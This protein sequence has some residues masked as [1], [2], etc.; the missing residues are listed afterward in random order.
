M[1]YQTLNLSGVQAAETSATAGRNCDSMVDKWVM[2]RGMA[3]G[4]FT[5]Q[6]T[7]DGTNFVDTGITV[8]ADG[9]VEVPQAAVAIRLNMSGATFT[10][11]DLRAGTNL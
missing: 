6:A 9:W 2:T 8:T 10:T 3:A 7:I 1:I 4:S 11:V 5:I